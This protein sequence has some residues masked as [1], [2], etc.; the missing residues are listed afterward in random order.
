MN[1]AAFVD[2]G[3]AVIADDHGEG[4]EGSGADGLGVCGLEVETL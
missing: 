2:D 4:F 3:D 1:V